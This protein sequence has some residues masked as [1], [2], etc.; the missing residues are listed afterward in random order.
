MALPFCTIC[1]S[2][3]DTEGKLSCEAFPQG[4]PKAVYP[5]GCTLRKPCQGDRGFG[6]KPKPGME[7]TARRWVRE[8]GAT[9][10]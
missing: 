2:L 10:P 3:G 1:E 6:F 8:D 7:E 9:R 4:I 5:G